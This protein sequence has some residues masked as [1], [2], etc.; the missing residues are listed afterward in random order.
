MVKKTSAL[1]LMGIYEWLLIRISGLLI[2]LYILCI[3]TF[4][5]Y[6]APINYIKWYCFFDKKIIKVFTILTLLSVAL[7]AWIGMWQVITDYIK[8]K[9][10]RLIIQTI[11]CFMLLFYLIYGIKILI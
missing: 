9:L 1:G 11:T 7:H 8:T 5:I 4:I 6:N 10:I 2:F 3:T